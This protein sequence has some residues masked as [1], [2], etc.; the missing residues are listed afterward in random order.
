VLLVGLALLVLI[1]IAFAVKGLGS[2]EGK[3][4]R[5]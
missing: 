2:P 4:A 3:K 1:M 5:K